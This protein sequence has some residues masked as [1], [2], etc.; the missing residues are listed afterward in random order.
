VRLRARA[1]VREAERFLGLAERADGQPLPREGRVHTY[2]LTDTEV[3]VAETSQ[4][5][6]ERGRHELSPLLHAGQTVV[7]ELIRIAGAQERGEPPE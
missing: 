6:L 5:A 4:R 2:F 7:T 3:L 1:I